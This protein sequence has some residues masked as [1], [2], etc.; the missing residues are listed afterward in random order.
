MYNL[1][2][3][4]DILYR[5]C[6]LVSYNTLDR[7]T[8]QYNLLTAQYNLLTSISLGT[9]GVN[10]RRYDNMVQHLLYARQDLQNNLKKKKKI[11]ATL[12]RQIPALEKE[13][14]QKKKSDNG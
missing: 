1:L 7:L 12:I 5:Y 6:K 14:L 13:S 10:R 2:T 11:K 3:V 9:L 4:V 8:V